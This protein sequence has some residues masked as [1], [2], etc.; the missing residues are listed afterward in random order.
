MILEGKGLKAR[1]G[2]QKH[3]F[4]SPINPKTAILT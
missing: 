4:F 1:K 3:F 2:Q